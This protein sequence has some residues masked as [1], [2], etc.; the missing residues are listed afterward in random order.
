M[1]ILHTA[2]LPSTHPLTLLLGTLLLIAWLGEARADIYALGHDAARRTTVL[3][4]TATGED[5][6]YRVADCCVIAN[7]SA[8][9]DTL[10]NRAFFIAQT[11]A[12][13]ELVSFNYL[14]GAQSRLPLSGPYRVTHMEYDPASGQL[15]ALARD[16][17]DER[18]VMVGIQPLTGQISLRASLAEPCCELKTGVSVLLPGSPT[19]VLAVGRS[20]GEES[21]LSFDFSAGTGPSAIALPAKLRVAELAVHP[22]S[23]LLFGVGFNEDT[24]LSHAIAFGAGPGFTPTLIGAGSNDCCFVLAGSA[25]ID[26]MGNSLAV[27]G[28]GSG[29]AP[30]VQRFSLFDGSRSEGIELQAHALLEDFGVR[31]GGLFADGFE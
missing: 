4:S 11:A 7:G 15:L 29:G 19:R 22:A 18:V 14:S 13:A 24:G 26:R 21:L 9:F 23:A 6:A 28:Q 17:V 1:G 20:G 10:G 5:T 2:P 8:T 12:G 16:T 25:A 31:F 27:L 30:R 3:R